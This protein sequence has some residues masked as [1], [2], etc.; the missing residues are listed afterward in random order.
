MRA[1]L[2]GWGGGWQVANSEVA[3]CHSFIFS[4]ALCTNQQSPMLCTA[5]LHYTVE[6]I[7]YISWLTY[8]T[9]APVDQYHTCFAILKVV[10]VSKA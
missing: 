3:I 4:C 10:N 5:E 9:L 1:A 6:A 7:A 2:G 8:G